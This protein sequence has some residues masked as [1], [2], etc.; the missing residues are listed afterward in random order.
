[1][2]YLTEPLDSTHNKSTFSSGKDMLDNY[3]WK[4]AG[5]D[6][7][8][9]LAACFVAVE[10]ES[11]KILGYY[12]LSSN[13]ISNELIPNFLRKNFYLRLNTNNFAWQ[14]SG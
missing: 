9:K 7:K 4:Q 13:S 14:T 10:K 2:A 1:M 6:V 12:T 5:Q 8:E 11:K 3:F